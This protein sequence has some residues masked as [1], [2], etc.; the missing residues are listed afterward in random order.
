MAKTNPVPRLSVQTQAT[1]STPGS[2]QGTVSRRLRGPRKN[3]NP[4]LF[5]ANPDN[6]DEEVHHS[7]GSPVSLGERGAQRSPVKGSPATISSN[8]SGGRPMLG[9]SSSGGSGSIPIIP[10]GQGSPRSNLPPIPSIP[11]PQAS[12]LPAVSSSVPSPQPLPP[13]PG[14]P[15]PPPQPERHLA[16]SATTPYPAQQQPRGHSSRPSLGA[17]PFPTSPS[18]ALPPLPMPSPTITPTP[19]PNVSPARE[20]PSSAPAAQQAH[21]PAP[22][23]IQSSVNSFGGQ[24][25]RMASPEATL[26]PATATS[27]GSRGLMGPTEL[28]NRARSGSFQSQR[29][30]L[31]VTTDN[32][33]FT[34]VDITGMTT[35]EGIKERVFSKVGS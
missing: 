30:K 3:V 14:P 12:P 4:G 10:A 16:R 21:P 23:P 27:D 7:G 24:Q 26:S 19:Q 35:A 8:G 9:S 17:S 18:R 32:E 29:I 33:S 1:P 11:A 5:I 20:F 25:Q 28:G 15:Q 22:S 13:T 6:S 31:Q 2:T 34:T